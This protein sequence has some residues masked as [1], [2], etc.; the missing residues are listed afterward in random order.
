MPFPS[1][2][3]GD[4]V[5]T[6]DARTG[7]RRALAWLVLLTLAGL[8]LLTASAVHFAAGRPLLGA[9]VA[10]AGLGYLAA[11]GWIARRSAVRGPAP[12][13]VLHEG[14]VAVSGTPG[15]AWEDLASVAMSGVRRKRRGVTRW[16]F[17]VTTA[18]GRVLRFGDALPD[19]RVLG[20]AIVARTGAVALPRHLRALEEGRAVRFGPFRVDGEGVAKDGRRLPWDAVRDVVI[21]NGLVTVRAAGGADGLTATAAATPD[22]LVLAELCRR[23]RARARRAPVPPP[24]R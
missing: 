6:F 4:P 8:A 17:D 11:A 16:R 12:V 7:R 24:R 1:R 18:D 10:A 9:A 19:V 5:R 21:A 3:L 22:A 20:E 23:A 15:Y 13:V 2:P 14:G